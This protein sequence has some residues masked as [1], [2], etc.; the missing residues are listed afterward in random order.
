MGGDGKGVFYD[1]RYEPQRGAAARRRRGDRDQCRHS[2][3][4][5]ESYSHEDPGTLRVNGEQTVGSISEQLGE[6][7]G[8]ISYH[9][10]QLAHAGLV[11]KVES[12]DG[13]RRK[14]WWKACQS[15]IRL[16]NSEEKNSADESKAMDLF[17]RSAALSYEMAYERF[18]DRLPEL[19]REWADSCTSDDHVLNLTAEETSL[20]IEELNEVVRRWQIRAGMHGD[21]ELGVEP[22]ALIL[23]AFRWVS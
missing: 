18:L 11:K 20:M 14:S 10:G 4:H 23:Q 12:P 1:E 16:G 22:V 2:L 7:P 9:L 21:D 13:D 15:A 6:A 8:A 19:P 3:G 5:G 17:R